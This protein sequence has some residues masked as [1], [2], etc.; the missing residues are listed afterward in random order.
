MSHRAGSRVVFVGN[1]PYDIS[2]EQLINVFSEVGRVAAFRLVS[3]KEQGKFK[4]YGFCE[5]EDVE[6]AASAVRNLNDVEV[7]GRQL[8][9]DFADSDPMVELE[10]HTDA[11]KPAGTE[12]GTP[13]PPGVS[14]TDAITHA[15]A[16]LPPNQLMDILTQMKSLSAT[17][18]EQARAL[19]SGNPQLAYAVFH[20]MLMMNIVDPLIVQRVLGEAG[21]IPGASMHVPAPMPAQ[22]PAPVPAMPA[23]MPM[24]N[25]TPTPAAQAQLDEQQRV[26]LSQVLQLTPEQINA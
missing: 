23:Q 20:S 10:R 15:I 2:E 3:D 1:I 9:L 24:K 6:T 17:S 21:A 4:G 26:L 8:R 11:R 13:L 19:L 22:M 7:G 14:A 25:A 18:P 16:S 12:Q 5:Y